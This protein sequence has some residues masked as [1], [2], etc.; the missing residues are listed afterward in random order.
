MVLDGINF[1]N[2]D[3]ENSVGYFRAD[4]VQFVPVFCIGI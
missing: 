4:I 3:D 1:L 2:C